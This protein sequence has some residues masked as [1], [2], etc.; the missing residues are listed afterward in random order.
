MGTLVFDTGRPA[1]I[2]DYAD[3]SGPNADLA[4]AARHPLRSPGSRS[5]WT[6]RLWGVIAVMSTAKS[7]LP[8]DTEAR[9]AGFTELAAT[10]I[11]NAHAREERRE[12]AAEQAALR[13]VA[14][15]VARGAPPDEVFTAIAREVGRLF[16]TQFCGVIRFNPDA[17]RRPSGL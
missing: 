15:L 4:R 9:L 5:A 11:A 12:V 17:R 10:A 8:A 7:R 13:R 6:G 2:D 1:R 16:G 14:T 3:A